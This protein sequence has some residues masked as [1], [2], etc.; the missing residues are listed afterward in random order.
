MAHFSAPTNR[1]AFPVFRDLTGRVMASNRLRPTAH[2]AHFWFINLRYWGGTINYSHFFGQS[3]PLI[4][5]RYWGRSPVLVVRLA[6][7]SANNLPPAIVKAAWFV[8]VIYL[9]GCLYGNRGR[10]IF[11]GD[12]PAFRFEHG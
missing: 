2:W 10:Q 5:L 1:T 8:V 7:S 12:N 9:R 6:A 3:L 4:R 11:E